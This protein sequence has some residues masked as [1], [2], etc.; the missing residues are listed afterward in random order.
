[1]SNSRSGRS[2]SSVFAGGGQHL[3]R[4]LSVEMDPGEPLADEVALVAGLGGVGGT[5]ARL[6]LWRRSML[7]LGFFVLLPSLLIDSIS[8]IIQLAD[9]DVGGIAVD[10]DSVAVLGGLGFLVVCLNAVM[11]FGVYSAFRR[12]SDWGASRKVL[13]ITWVIAFLAPFAVALFPMRSVAGGNAQAAIIFGLL[14]ALNHVVALAPKVL[15]LIPG[16]LRAAVS[17]KVLFPQTSAPGWLV[18][19]ASPFYLLLLFVIMMLPYQL[20]GSP[21]LMLAML[22]F[23]L[24][25]VWLWRS[26]TALARPTRPEETVALV[27]KTRGVSI[28]LNGAGAVL[29]LIGVLTAGIGIDALSVFKALIGI[30][31]NVLILSVVAIDVLI[32]GMSRARTIAREVVSDEADPLDTFMDEAAAATGPPPEG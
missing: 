31:A 7:Y 10:K 32:G 9:N 17:A 25:P 2:G 27:K 23:L 12:W 14:G 28:A 4:A 15:A 30:A 13:L 16:L 3:R 24:G 1:M 19:L 6:L 29:L 18:T 8:A 11:A 21:L 20:T 5:Y 26:G 22:C